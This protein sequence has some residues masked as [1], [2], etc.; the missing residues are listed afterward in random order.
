MSKKRHNEYISKEF[1]RAARGY[2]KS[3]VVKS[4]QRQAQI[5]VIKRMLIEKGMKILDLGCGTGAGTIDISFRLE[6]TGKAIG[7]DL[8]EKMIEQARQ[9]LHNHEYGNIE[10]MVGSLDSLDYNNYFD[11]VL[12][13]NAFHHFSDKEAI[14]LKIKKSLKLNGVFIIQDICDDYLLMKI[15]DFMGRIGEKAHVS[16]TTLQKLK[17]LF[18]STGF[19]DIKLDKIKLNWFWG[20]MVGE[21]IN[22]TVNVE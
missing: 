11:Y 10:F 18:L 3:L 19:S 12:S 8:S 13:T 1:D 6:G 17:G 9:K 7:L 4:Y 14:F 21:G 2:D 22:L 16:S 20:I 5:L 15:L